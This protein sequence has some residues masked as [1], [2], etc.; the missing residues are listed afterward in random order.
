MM[1]FVGEKGQVNVVEVVFT[2]C[3]PKRRDSRFSSCQSSSEKMELRACWING[4]I[5]LSSGQRMG[6]DEVPVMVP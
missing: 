1:V 6:I 4:S 5:S 3:V 2:R